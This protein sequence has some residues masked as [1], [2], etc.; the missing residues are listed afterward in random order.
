MI[1]QS[2]QALQKVEQTQNILDTLAPHDILGKIQYEELKKEFFAQWLFWFFDEEQAMKGFPS[3][4]AEIYNLPVLP[5]KKH[6][7]SYLV[8]LVYELL[9]IIQEQKERFFSS[10]KEEP[11]SDFL[12]KW[13]NEIQETDAPA[14]TKGK[15]VLFDA[16]VLR[17]I[18][19]ENT[20]DAINRDTWDEPS[21]A[22]VE[23]IM[24]QIE[25]LKI[26]WNVR[27]GMS[28]WNCLSWIYERTPDGYEYKY[29]L[30]Y[31][32]QMTKRMR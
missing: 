14:D 22:I 27:Q 21:M 16:L 26:A 28:V 8:F 31:F 17:L 18:A 2:Q 1:E 20:L 9:P 5:K 30:G 24:K 13:Y 29:R 4:T 15:K 32:L 10:E 12:L 23:K 7:T 6:Q 3:T 19:S 25:A 11:L